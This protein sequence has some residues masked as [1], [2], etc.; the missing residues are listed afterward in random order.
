MTQLQL[1]DVISCLDQATATP[2]DI[3]DAISRARR[4]G[5]TDLLPEWMLAPGRLREAAMRSARINPRPLPTINLD[6][7]DPAPVLN[8]KSRASGIPAALLRAV[9]CRELS[10]PT[11]P[12]LPPHMT[13]QFC[14][15]ARVNSFIRL[16]QGDPD[17]RTDDADLLSLLS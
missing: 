7:H 2:R 15:H 11:T 3:R 13:R 17:A 5:R 12:E 14:A 1:Q 6:A 4:A 16:S 10:N 9:Y 8:A